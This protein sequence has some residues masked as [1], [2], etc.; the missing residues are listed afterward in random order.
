MDHKHKQYLLFFYNHEV[1]N[2][3]RILFIEASN[4]SQFQYIILDFFIIYDTTVHYVGAVQ[5]RSKPFSNVQCHRILS[6]WRICVVVIE[7]NPSNQCAVCAG[8][9]YSKEG[10]IVVLFAYQQPN[11]ISMSRAGTH[12]WAHTRVVSLGRVNRVDCRLA[13]GDVER[14]YVCIWESASLK[15]AIKKKSFLSL[16]RFSLD[17]ENVFS[18]KRTKGEALR[19]P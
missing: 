14:V 5:Y 3:G 12:V 6:H 4:K 8:V 10:S 19:H 15:V 13:N 17:R 7:P 1:S 18:R 16:W 9:C 11:N 2:V